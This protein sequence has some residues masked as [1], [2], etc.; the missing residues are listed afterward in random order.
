MSE[1]QNVEKQSKQFESRNSFEPATSHAPEPTAPAEPQATGEPSVEAEKQPE[2][3]SNSSQEEGELPDHFKRRLGK[4]Q[5]KHERELARVRAE[6]DEMRARN[7]NQNVPYGTAPQHSDGYTDPL[8]GEFIDM[9]TPYGQEIYKYQQKL[10]QKLEQDQRYQDERSQKEV[11]SRIREHMEDSRDEAR[12]KFSDYDQVIGSARI[13]DNTARELGNFPDPA[14]LAYYIASNP[15]EVER[16]QRLPAYELRR[17]LA[18][19][20]GDMVSKKN[21]T[22]TPPPVNPVGATGLQSSKSS[23][24]KSLA[25]MKAE[26]KAAVSGRR[27]R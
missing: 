13:S 5:K 27:N 24:H 8:T 23:L 11:E 1:Q 25:E 2:V 21:I 22:R 6:L 20:M 26:R 15:R 18:R 10:S 7:G 16:I 3:V 17:E 12:E 14:G 4:E 19:H 9:S